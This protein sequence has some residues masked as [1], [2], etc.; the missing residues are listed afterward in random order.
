MRKVSVAVKRAWPYAPTMRLL[1][2]S[3]IVLTG[4]SAVVEDGLSDGLRADELGADITVR[5]SVSV[6]R[7]DAVSNQRVR[8]HVAAR[9]LRAAGLIDEVTVERVAGSAAIDPSAPLGCAWRDEASVGNADGIIELLDVGEIVLH[10]RGDEMALAPRAFPDV[11]GLISGVV[12]TSRDGRA[13]LPEGA[14]Y[15]FEV[16]GSRALDG[17]SLQ[18]DAPAAPSD[19]RIGG[20]ALD[21]SELVLR[22]GEPADVTWSRSADLMQGDRIYI[23]ATGGEGEAFTCVFDDV[24]QALIPGGFVGFDSGADLDLIVHRHRRA[25]MTVPGETYEAVVDFDFAVA[26]PVAVVD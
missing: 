8:T 2:A 21:S 18:A 4:C 19:V 9:F 13:E 24:G 1:A 15:L 11:G 10:A 7:T 12:Y 22:A 3:L 26:A 20:V 6:Q 25:A 14:T 5:A 16:T 23:T 17:F